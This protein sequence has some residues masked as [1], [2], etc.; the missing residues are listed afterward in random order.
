MADSLLNGF[1]AE[2]SPL[3]GMRVGLCSLGA[4]TS[5]SNCSGKETM[6]I[7]TTKE[8][9]GLQLAPPA[10]MGDVNEIDILFSELPQE[11]SQEGTQST[12]STGLKETPNGTRSNSEWR[13]GHLE[14][15]FAWH[16]DN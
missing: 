15:A 12:G 9:V 1:I 13:V 2:N 11:S 14:G 5:E 16:M 8:K 6:A 7:S 3:S 10:L 4:T